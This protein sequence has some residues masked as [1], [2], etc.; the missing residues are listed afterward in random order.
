METKLREK[1]KIL[2]FLFLRYSN[3][4]FNGKAETFEKLESQAERMTLQEINKMISEIGI[5]K[6]ISLEEIA[7]LVRLTNRSNNVNNL[8]KLICIHGKKN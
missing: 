6:I 8:K 5:S 4:G 3:T 2:K 7:R 1:Q